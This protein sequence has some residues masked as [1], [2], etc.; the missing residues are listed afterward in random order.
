MARR[1]GHR[2]LQHERVEGV[3]RFA[4]VGGAQVVGKEHGIE[5]A[6]LGD[7][8]E[9]LPGGEV[10]KPGRWDALSPAVGRLREAIA[11]DVQVQKSLRHRPILGLR[12]R[13]DEGDSATGWI[14]RLFVI[15]DGSAPA[16]TYER[17]PIV[18]RRR[19]SPL[20]EPG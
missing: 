13:T 15:G 4:E 3:P 2:S 10:E 14:K 7:L 11:V 16:S 8:P 19:T 6:A 5:Q 18:K 17:R 20:A 12:R 1:P 9:L